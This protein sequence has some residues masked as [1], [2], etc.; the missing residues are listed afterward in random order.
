[1]FPPETTFVVTADYYVMDDSHL[2]P[3]RYTAIA[4]KY[5]DVKRS[6]VSTG[7]ARKLLT[8][9][10]PYVDSIKLDSV[11]FDIFSAISDLSIFRKL[12]HIEFTRYVDVLREFFIRVPDFIIEQLETATFSGSSVLGSGVMYE[13]IPR[14]RN[15]KILQLNHAWEIKQMANTAILPSLHTLTFECVN[16][17]GSYGQLALVFAWIINCMPA[18]RVLNVSHPMFVMYDTLG[19]MMSYGIA[20][21]PYPVEDRHRST[22]RASMNPK[23]PL[24]MLYFIRHTRRNLKV[25]LLGDIYPCVRDYKETLDII[26]DRSLHTKMQLPEALLYELIKFI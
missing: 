16:I 3:S 7:D 13:H 14:M 6:D 19:E 12:K 2:D 9:F 4:F 26:L 25:N 22:D 8:R 20:E 1:M 18:L 15:L 17:T 24:D 11:W 23:D 5:I 21:K 10:A